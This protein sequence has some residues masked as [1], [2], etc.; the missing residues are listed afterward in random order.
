ML[1]TFWVCI[2]LQVTPH[3]WVALS[4]PL[5]QF[6][7]VA[8][9]QDLRCHL[10]QEGPRW[11]AQTPRLW[12]SRTGAQLHLTRTSCTSSELRSWPTRCWP[13]GSLC[14][15]TCRWQCRASGQCLGCSSRCQHYLH[16]LCLQQDLALARDLALGQGQDQHLQITAG[17]TVRPAI[18]CLRGEEGSQHT[19]QGRGSSGRQTWAQSLGTADV[20]IFPPWGRHSAQCLGGQSYCQDKYPFSSS[21]L[22]LDAHTT[23]LVVGCIP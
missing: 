22:S 11:M 18:P 12:G 2:S 7:P 8:Q 21:L 5:V 3:P 4:M 23:G 9:P 17:L 10:G 16:P 1:V 6:Q 13:E 19:D 15:I 14:L 20:H